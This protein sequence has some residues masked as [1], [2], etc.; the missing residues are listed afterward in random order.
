MA[1]QETQ[2]LVRLLDALLSRTKAGEISWESTDKEGRLM[3]SVSNGSILI[4][5]SD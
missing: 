3:H 2:K 1:D 4:T 5:Q